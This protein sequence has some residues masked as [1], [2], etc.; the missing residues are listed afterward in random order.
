[1]KRRNFLAGA[2]SIAMVPRVAA[3]TAG[4]PRKVAAFV[5]TAESDP[6]SQRRI[7]AFR[8]GLAELGWKDGQNV[9][10]EYRWAA[11]KVELIQQYADEL[12]ALAPDVILANG[13]PVIEALRR[14]TSSIPIVCALV[15]DPVGLGLVKS[16]SRPGG[17]ITGF[18]YINS[19]MI[20]KWTGLL[21]EIIPGFMQAAVMYNPKTTA[22]YRKFL[23]ELA[24]AKKDTASD[25]SEAPVGSVEEIEAAINTLAAKPGSGL[26]IGPDP[27]TSVHIKRI[28][29]LVRDK[30]LAAVAVHRQFA[31]EGGLMA[32]GPDPADAFR[33]SAGY[34]DRILKGASP[35]ELPV[36]QPDKF[37]LVVNLLAARALGVTVPTTLLATADQVIE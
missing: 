5:G 1:M 13:T 36:Q 37:E 12:V 8:Q 6:E 33:R 27:F 10:I 20:G 11:G 14:R 7:A 23:Q 32:Y 24:S 3:Q 15:I 21:K 18:T 31:V 17:N 19:E 26:I 34:V 16:L 30:G 4:G 22:Y 35:A 9:Q 25:V 28:A 29:N 2:I